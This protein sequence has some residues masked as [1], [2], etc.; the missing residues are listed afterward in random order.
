MY[1]QAQ[2]K[3]FFLDLNS[4]VWSRPLRAKPLILPFWRQ[5]SANMHPHHLISMKFSVSFCSSTFYRPKLKQMV[6]GTR[7]LARIFCFFSCRGKKKKFS[8]S[9]LKY[10]TKVLP[11]EES[12]E[13]HLLLHFNDVCRMCIVKCARMRQA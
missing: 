13:F 3:Y 6:D 7:F 10:L 11:K 12:K 4:H 8:F 1:E 2:K 9:S 5:Q